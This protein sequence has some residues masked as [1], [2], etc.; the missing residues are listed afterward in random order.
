MLYVDTNIMD[1][2]IIK[3]HVDIICLACRNRSM[4]HNRSFLLSDGTL[5]KKLFCV[6][7]WI[8]ISNHFSHYLF[9]FSGN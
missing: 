3:S 2:K 9:S 4:S 6:C 7:F 5:P 8:D 1:V